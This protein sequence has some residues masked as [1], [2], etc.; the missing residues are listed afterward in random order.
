MTDKQFDIKTAKVK[1]CPC[2]LKCTEGAHDEPRHSYFR[3]QWPEGHMNRSHY[4]RE[5]TC[6]HKWNVPL[7][8]CKYYSF[9]SRKQIDD[10][11][12]KLEESEKHLEA[13]REVLKL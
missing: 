9:W 6:P 3:C 1:D 10:A 5:M 12:K 2:R 8:G 4:E 11:F 13:F 7:N